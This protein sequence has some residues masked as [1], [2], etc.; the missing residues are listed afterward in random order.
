[1]SLFDLSLNRRPRFFGSPTSARHST[2]PSVEIL[3][4]RSCPS[5]AAP[6]GLQ[7]T[8]LSSTQV[9]LTWTNPAGSFGTR[10]LFWNGATTT[11]VAQLAKGVTTYTA[12][13]LKPNQTQW[14]SVQAFDNATSA[15]SAWAAIMT[16]P[17]AITAPTNLHV[18]GATQTQVNL[19]WT[20]GTG[21]TGYRI[22]MW[23]GTKAVQI[24]TTTPSVP[25]FT[26]TGLTPGTTYYF[27]VQ[28]FNATNSVS[29]DWV[30]ATTSSTSITAPSNVKATVVNSGT[31]GLSWKDS[32]GE[33]GYR[34][35]EWD[36]N[37][38]HGATLIASLA[39]N[40]TGYQAVG[41]V[42]GQTYYFYVQAFNAT[43]T[44]NTG[45]VSATT[46]VAAPLGPPTALTVQQTGTNSALISW[47]EPARAAG[48]VIYVWMGT[49]WSS[50]GNVPAGTHQFQ[51]SNL[52]VGQTN[53]FMVE[54]YTTNFAEVNYSSAVYVNL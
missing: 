1:M 13:N 25:A 31:I 28:A 43:A 14:F 54:S 51:A 35:Y 5:V 21:V 17:D 40:T 3:E 18:N 50:I 20:N 27:Y 53:W 52:L 33:T 16:P 24:G 49:A 11:T 29:T 23:D 37:A 2:R 12:S 4:E 47:T 44:A 9:K 46:T 39:A 41:L 26:A 48:Y 30:T 19:A 42:P 38:A 32:T 10:I 22:F 45:W 8:A 34:I 15:Q 36:G 7:L 6:T